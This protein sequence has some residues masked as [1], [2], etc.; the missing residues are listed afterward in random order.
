MP[1]LEYVVDH[2]EKRDYRR[3]VTALRDPHFDLLNNMDAAGV[4]LHS[5]IVF[6]LCSPYEDTLELL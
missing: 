1:E 5:N 2:M 4:N 6:K 3:L